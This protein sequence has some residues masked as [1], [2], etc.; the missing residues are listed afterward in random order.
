MNG[1][2]QN[3]KVNFQKVAPGLMTRTGAQACL[4]IIIK[5]EYSLMNYISNLQVGFQLGSIY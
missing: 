5:T 1:K 4:K 3:L 2:M